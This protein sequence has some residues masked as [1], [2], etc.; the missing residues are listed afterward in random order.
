MNV[1]YTIMCGGESLMLTPVPAVPVEMKKV[2]DV[3][4]DLCE[5]VS[6]DFVTIGWNGIPCTI[7]KRGS[8]LFYHVTDRT[9]AKKYFLEIYDKLNTA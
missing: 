5:K 4:E 3:F 1:S 2:T 8:I 6:E 9:A 7:Y